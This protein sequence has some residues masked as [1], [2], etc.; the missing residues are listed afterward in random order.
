M[1]PA[2][3]CTSV[4][5]VSVRLEGRLRSQPYVISG[6]GDVAAALRASTADIQATTA[7]IAAISLFVGAF[8][9]FNTLSMSVVERAREIA[10]LRAA[11]AV[12]SQLYWLVLLQA[13]V[14]AS[15]SGAASSSRA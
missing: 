13:I 15:I 5:A 10:L 7:L 1:F 12:R 2:V 6:P 9:I 14:I 4:D 8:L 11:G 3:S